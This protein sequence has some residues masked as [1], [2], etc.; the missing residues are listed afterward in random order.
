MSDLTLTAYLEKK[1]LEFDGICAPELCLTSVTATD[2]YS[3]TYYDANTV[4]NS[5]KP[6]KYVNGRYVSYGTD[7]AATMITVPFCKKDTDCTKSHVVAYML[8]KGR[9]AVECLDCTEPCGEIKTS[10]ESQVDITALPASYKDQKC[11]SQCAKQI[12]WAEGYTLQNKMEWNDT[13]KLYEKKEYKISTGTLTTEVTIPQICGIS[14]LSFEF[15]ISDCWARWDFTDM[16]TAAIPEGGALERIHGGKWSH[17]WDFVNS[18]CFFPGEYM[19]VKAHFDQT[20]CDCNP[21]PIAWGWYETECLTSGRIQGCGLIEDVTKSVKKERISANTYPGSYVTYQN[22][23]DVVV[24]DLEMTKQYPPYYSYAASEILTVMLSQSL[25]HRDIQN[26]KVY[27]SANKVAELS[28]SDYTCNTS[29]GELTIKSS[30]TAWRYDAVTVEYEYIVRNYSVDATNGCIKVSK[31]SPDIDEGSVLYIDYKWTESTI[32]AGGY[33]IPL[34]NEWIG[35]KRLHWY[36]SFKGTLCWLPCSDFV[37]WEIGDRVLV[38]KGGASSIGQTISVSKYIMSARSQYLNHKN[39]VSL[40]VYNENKT[41]LYQNEVDYTIDR[42]NGILAETPSTSIVVGWLWVEY[43]YAEESYIQM[44]KC[45]NKDD[46]NKTPDE[47][48]ILSHSCVA[49]SLDRKSDLILP[50]RTGVSK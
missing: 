27:L 46:A 30:S 37:K 6:V 7:V 33:L 11:L 28:S 48:R 24:W 15:E 19:V 45:R 29:T 35:D 40:R 50:I 21:I 2:V 8:P 20:F 32:K 18:S 44:H 41:V 13:T 4:L 25:K 22:I 38:L 1:E 43:T 5:K 14:G 42:E 31:T 39:I 10:S 36:V 16:G 26:I 34:Q 3:T 9:D 49:Y 23:K 47:D 12:S 17:T